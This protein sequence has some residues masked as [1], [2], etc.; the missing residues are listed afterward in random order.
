MK[1]QVRRFRPNFGKNIFIR[2]ENDG[3]LDESG[4]KLDC[5]AIPD[6][7][8]KIGPLGGLYSC[9][10]A[11]SEDLLFFTPV[12]APFTNTDAA[13]TLCQTLEQSIDT[14]PEKYACVLVHPTRGKQ[15]L[16]AAYAKTCLP[17][18]EC[19]IQLENYRLRQ[20]LTPEHTIIADILVP[21]EHFYNMNDMPS[22]YHAL[23]MLAEKQPALFPA[24][25]VPQTEQTIP[26]VSFSAKSGTGKTTYLE[27]LVAC[28]KEK[29]LTY[30]TDQAMNAHGFE[31][32]QPGK[33]SYLSAKSRCGYYD[34]KWSGANCT[35][36]DT[37]YRR[38]F[39]ETV[40][41]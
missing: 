19:M 3:F 30:C 15:P 35:D 29:G 23:Q 8:E 17:N 21:Q 10:S 18:I 33:D 12:D 24:D 38:T 11:V 25:F 40:A 1:Y 14:V 5:Q 34:F 2:S 22:Y 16:T 28:L 4:R 20:L 26:Y 41:F 39:S 9:L 13:L 32:D 27:K 31:I 6:R 37:C 36:T 7:I